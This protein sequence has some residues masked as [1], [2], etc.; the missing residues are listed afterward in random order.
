MLFS[1]KTWPEGVGFK[2]YYSTW[3]DHKVLRESRATAAM[4]TISIET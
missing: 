4:D 2:R 3:A 1:Q